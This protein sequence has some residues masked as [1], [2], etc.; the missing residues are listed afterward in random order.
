MFDTPMQVSLFGTAEPAPDRSFASLQ[1]VRL[2][3]EAWI[4]VAPGWLA[5]D[6]TMYDLLIDGVQWDQPVVR[7]YDRD[8]RTPRLVG[9]V[10]TDLHPVIGELIRLLSDRYDVLLDQVSVGWYR[11]GRDSVAWHGDRIARDRRTATVATVSL[12]HPRRFPAPP[13][14][15][16]PFTHLVAWPWRPRGD[17]RLLPA[18][19][20]ARRPQGGARRPTDGVDVPPRLLSP[21]WRRSAGSAEGRVRHAIGQ[22]GEPGK[23]SLGAGLWRGRR[24]E[25]TSIT[26]E[27]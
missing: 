1:R 15:R 10:P 27:A 9:R 26:T 3:G 7:M 4:D 14:G 13:Q 20:G 18:D 5:G 2:D 8:V 6:E 23:D 17:G 19:L 11:D 25:P 16:R 21:G 12:G 22:T 24:P